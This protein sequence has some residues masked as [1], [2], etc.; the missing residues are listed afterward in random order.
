M[1]CPL[2]SRAQHSGL[3]EVHVDGVPCLTRHALLRIQV[4]L[5]MTIASL[6]LAQCGMV[7]F[8]ESF[9]RLQ[10]AVDTWDS[11]RAQAAK[12]AAPHELLI[13]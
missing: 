5:G 3:R 7:R 13:A 2:S 1:P 10:E 12:N 8:R 11:A 4:E 6:V 9:L